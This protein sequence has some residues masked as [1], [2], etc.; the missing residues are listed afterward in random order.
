MISAS[1]DTIYFGCKE[2]S[3]NEPVILIQLS[4]GIFAV[5]DPTVAVCRPSGSWLDLRFEAEESY[6][7][8]VTDSNPNSNQVAAHEQY[9][10]TNGPLRV[11]A[12][13]DVPQ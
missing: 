4:V 2:T 10:R 13:T 6:V 9:R 5:S 11:L 8:R 1:S 7:C 3:N 12:L